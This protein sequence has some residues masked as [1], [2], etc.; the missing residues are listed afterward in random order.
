MRS[1]AP[2]SGV[3]RNVNST[4]S[5]SGTSITRAKYNALI[6]TTAVT[7]VNSVEISLAG[8]VRATYGHLIFQV[9]EGPTIKPTYAVGRAGHERRAGKRIKTFRWS[10]PAQPITAIVADRGARTQS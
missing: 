7:T 5:A 1:S 8:E 3:R 2:A 6:T 10:A 4:A 9:Q